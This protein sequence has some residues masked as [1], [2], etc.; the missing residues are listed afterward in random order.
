MY[1]TTIKTNAATG[2]VLELAG[3]GC[4]A[5]DFGIDSSVTRLAGGVGLL[6]SGK[7]VGAE[8]VLTLRQHIG[9]KN[10]GFINHLTHVRSFFGTPAAI[11]AGSAGIVNAKGAYDH[12]ILTVN[13]AWVASSDTGSTDHTTYIEN[14]YSQEFDMMTIIGSD[15]FLCNSGL[16]VMPQVPN[17]IGVVVDSTNLDSVYHFGVVVAPAPGAL[18]HDIRI[19][20]SWIAPGYAGGVGWGIYLGAGSVGEIKVSNTAFK[21][22]S[23]G[24]GIG[25]F[26]GVVGNIRAHFSNNSIAGYGIGFFAGNDLAHWS[27]TGG[28]VSGSGTGILVGTGNTNYNITSVQNCENTIPINN[29]SP[30]GTNVI[31]G[32]NACAP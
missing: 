17:V 4:V 15:G 10:A 27:L 9:F 5:R 25:I 19:S 1:A 22:Y 32:L 6:L 16:A 2:V 24:Q 30:T 18:A 28:E 29:S 31:L 7:S 3:Q 23:P 26:M 8:R 14:C 21:T 20:N 13:D 11:A 12:S